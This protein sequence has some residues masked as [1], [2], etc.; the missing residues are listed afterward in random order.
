MIDTVWA[1]SQILVEEE[2]VYGCSMSKH[3]YTGRRASPGS[4]KRCICAGSGSA[5]RKGH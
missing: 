2:D 1:N 5:K 3:S 4:G